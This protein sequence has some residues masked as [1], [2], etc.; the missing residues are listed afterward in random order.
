LT[1]MQVHY[2][3]GVIDWTAGCAGDGTEEF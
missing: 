2:P 3:P 1:L